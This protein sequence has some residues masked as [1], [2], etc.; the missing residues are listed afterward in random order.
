MEG[1]IEMGCPFHQHL[2]PYL[3]GELDHLKEKEM[4]EHLEACVACQEELDFLLQI[5]DSL[6][7]AA[8]SAKAP[9]LLREK[10]L[11]EARQPRRTVL[12]PR[13]NFVYGAA[14]AATVLFA[15][16]LIFYYHWPLERD[17][18]RYV[19]ASIVRY[20]AE[21]ES[22]GRSLDIKSSDVQ[23]AESWLKRRLD[24]KIPIPR[25]AFAGYG[26]E[27]ADIFE[28]KGRKFAYLKYRGNGKTI[29]YVIFKD[30]AFRI[31][32]PETVDIGE[33]KLHVGEKEETNFAVW[34]KGELVYVILTTEDRSE[35][36]EYARLCIQLFLNLTR[37][38]F[39]YSFHRD[40]F[41][42]CI[43]VFA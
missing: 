25:A 9:E 8:A 42:P 12:I 10:I 23:D 18:F 24:F 27:G 31:D 15:I 7:Q 28:Q 3:D 20:H 1:I 37:N 13:W 30:P 40:T 36:I 41:P 5:R 33:I 21:Y 4:E 2:S 16:T 32:L 43:I 11:G 29:G 39:G 17:S 6:K 38:E 34:K 35:L 26:L 19:V 22:G 14:L